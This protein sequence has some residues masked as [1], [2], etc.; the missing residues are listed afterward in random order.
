MCSLLEQRIG[1]SIYPSPCGHLAGVCRIFWDTL[2][3]LRSHEERSEASPTIEGNSA[4]LILGT[5][6]ELPAFFSHISR[7]VRM[8]FKLLPEFKCLSFQANEPTFL[9]IFCWSRNWY[10][11]D[12]D[13]ALSPVVCC[14]CLGNAS[15]DVIS[16]IF[17][18]C[19]LSSLVLKECHLDNSM[20]YYAIRTPH[21]IFQLLLS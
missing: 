18:P 8:P 21:V 16:G 15:M 4:Y 11:L 7:N 20:R 1:R 19:F 10:I 2:N 9:E 13:A 3:C 14:R 17:L 12:P 5:L 6:T